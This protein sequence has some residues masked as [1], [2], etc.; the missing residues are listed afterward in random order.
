MPMHPPLYAPHPHVNHQSSLALRH[1]WATHSLP[2]MSPSRTAS[3]ALNPNHYVQLQ[4]QRHPS[5]PQPRSNYVTACA[6]P[7]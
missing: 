6:A 3:I 5:G 7:P 1:L 2:K 4:Q